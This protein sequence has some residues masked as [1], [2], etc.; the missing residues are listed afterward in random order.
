[1]DPEIINTYEQISQLP[2][3]IRPLFAKHNIDIDPDSDLQ[4]MLDRCAIADQGPDSSADALELCRAQRVLR[5]ILDCGDEPEIKEPLNRIAS[6]KLDF[7]ST[8]HSLGQD[9]VFELEFLQYVRHRGRTARLG[10]PDIIVSAPSGDYFVACKSIN[11]LTNFRKQL[12]SGTGQVKKYGHGC[13]AFNL[14]RQSKL[15]QPLKVEYANEVKAILDAELSEFYANNTQRFN[16][17]LKEGSLDGV[18]LQISCFADIAESGV[19]LNVCTHTV[20]YSRPSLQGAEAHDRFDGF[21]QS[22]RGQMG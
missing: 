19:D 4:R 22:M 10:E 15:E 7:S 20:F 8:E 6:S 5:A 11:S 21:R 18:V 13:V 9:A 16:R 14:E 1:M 17:L 12:S 3:Q 2:T